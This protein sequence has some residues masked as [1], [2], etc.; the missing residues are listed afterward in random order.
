MFT[1]K[2]EWLKDST[3]YKKRFEKKNEIHNNTNS[4]SSVIP[5]N[6]GG[7]HKNSEQPRKQK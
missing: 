7:L 2:K 6:N 4:C 5:I 3:E 1:I